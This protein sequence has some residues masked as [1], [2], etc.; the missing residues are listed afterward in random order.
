MFD[1]WY[2][3]TRYRRYK[4]LNDRVSHAA[5]QI[6]SGI[7]GEEYVVYD[8]DGG[9]IAIDLLS[10]ATATQ[11]FVATW[12]NP[13]TGEEVKGGNVHG[14]ARPI[15]TSPFAADSVLFLKRER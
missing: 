4:Q 15:L 10:D 13:A 14:G 5:L 8:Q 9:A 12:Y 7:P 1:F 3:K 11:Y 6:A 2:T